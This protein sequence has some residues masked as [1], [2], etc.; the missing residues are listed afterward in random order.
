MSSGQVDW[1]SIG[2]KV[3]AESEEKGRSADVAT[4]GPGGLPTGGGG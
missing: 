2:V 4:G 1:I 3:S